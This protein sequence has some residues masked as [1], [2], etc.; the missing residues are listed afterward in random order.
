MKYILNSAF[1]FCFTAL[2]SCGE[3]EA[4]RE[5]GSE[6]TKPGLPAITPS[7]LPANTTPLPVSAANVQVNNNATTSSAAKLNPAHGQPGHR[8]DISVGAALPA[9]SLPNLKPA[10]LNS[11]VVNSPIQATPSLQTKS[12]VTPIV[13]AGINPAHGQP[14]HR[15]DVAVGAALPKDGAAPA[16][17]TT[18]N[19]PLVAQPV[20]NAPF[21]QTQPQTNT[22]STTVATGLNPAHG[23]PG[24]RCDIEVGKPLN[25]TP[26][27]N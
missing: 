18:P 20:A 11:P 8:C 22:A 25:S 19:S 15:C 7:T 1:F 3:N 24:H 23:Q 6:T 26:K 10:A 27:K 9:A 16:K 14:G 12:V 17:T 21:I 5:S 2:I 4:D 13:A